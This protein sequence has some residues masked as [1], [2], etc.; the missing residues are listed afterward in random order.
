MAHIG[1]YPLQLW[2]DGECQRGFSTWR[3]VESYRTRKSYSEYHVRVA[4]ASQLVDMPVCFRHATCN[5]C[6]SRTNCIDVG[7]KV[8]ADILAC[9]QPD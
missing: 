7:F 3:I 5:T 9:W 4:N 1:Q 2:R 8:A 6:A